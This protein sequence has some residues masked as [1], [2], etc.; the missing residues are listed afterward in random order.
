MA[1]VFAGI[2]NFCLF[3]QIGLRMAPKR[4][5]WSVEQK[6]FAVQLKRTEP[7][8]SLDAIIAAIHVKFGQDLARSTLSQWIKQGDAIEAQYNASGSNEAK[9]ARPAKNPKLEQALFL[10]YKS[11]E[12]RGS[13]ISGEVLTA[14]AKELA[15][16][17][18]LEVTEGFNCSA[19][20]LTNFK[21]RFG[22]SSHQRHG[23][24]GS[25]P[26]LS[27]DHAQ[28]KLRVLLSALPDAHGEN[29]VDVQPHNIFTMDETGLYWCQQPSRTLARGKTTGNVK[30]KK[31]MTVALVVNATGTEQLRPIIIHTA[32][33]PRAFPKG[34]NVEAGLGVHWHC[35][36][37][38]SMLSTVFQDWIT[39]V[40][41]HFSTH[42]C[43]AYVCWSA[44][45]R[46]L[47]AGH[48][49]LAKPSMQRAP[50]QDLPPSAHQVL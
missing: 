40:R 42:A 49:D 36:R 5:A 22:I 28:T 30:D 23:E 33:K 24:A 18:E 2:L 10:W 15:A 9:R 12:T 3:Y 37:S 48:P 31:R 7:T 32:N 19:G 1:E 46:V 45:K 50:R 6:W 26:E 47:Q 25:A 21:K 41:M 38:A 29:P 8:K 17:P 27:V 14:K 16:R 43:R 35:N 20:W 11:H 44:V 34:F 13:P 39:K 4:Y